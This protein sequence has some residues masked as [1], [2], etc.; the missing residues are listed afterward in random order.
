MIGS[1][2]SD[3]DTGDGHVAR[4][5]DGRWTQ[6]LLK[7]QPQKGFSHRGHPIK[8]WSDDLDNF[9]GAWGFA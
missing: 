5:I 7:W 9:F 3:T 8:R 6:K 4:C 1:W 2:H